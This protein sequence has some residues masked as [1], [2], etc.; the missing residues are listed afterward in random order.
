MPYHYQG[1]FH[2]I[3]MSLFF[4]I[5]VDGILSF[6]PMNCT[7]LD[8]IH[9]FFE[10]SFNPAFCAIA[11]DNKLYWSQYGPSKD[12]TWF[13]LERWVIDHNFLDMT[14]QAIPYPSNSPSV[15]PTPLHLVSRMLCRMVSKALQKSRQNDNS[16]SFLVHWCSHSIIES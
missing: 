13:P 3:H 1:V 12:T 7:S 4:K 2:D 10:G 8:V 5:S 11:K 14:I 15:K 9:K 16:S 6:K